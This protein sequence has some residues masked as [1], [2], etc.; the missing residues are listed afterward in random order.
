[1]NS[2]VNIGVD[3]G[4]TTVKVVV[5]DEKH[6]ILFKE[7]RRHLADV[8]G[9]ISTVLGSLLH[10]LGDKS[11]HITITGSAG[12][13]IAERCS[14]PFVQEVVASCELIQTL[15]PTVKTLVDIG[16]EDSKMIFFSPN[17]APDMRGVIVT[18]KQIGRAHV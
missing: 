15:Y 6:T 8:A 2:I 13:G 17:H 7:Y 4:S 18:G 9:V 3:A 5:T 11:V 16:G 14:L 1:M 12:M 10:T